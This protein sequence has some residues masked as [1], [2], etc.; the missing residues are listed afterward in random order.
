MN[1]NAN[2]TGKVT[3]EVTWVIVNELLHLSVRNHGKLW[4]SRMRA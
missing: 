2:A 3:E 4:K 1:M